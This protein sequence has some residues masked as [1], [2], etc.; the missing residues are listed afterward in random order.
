MFR[1]QV[2][3]FFQHALSAFG[4]NQFRMAAIFRAAFSSDQSHL[5]HLVDQ[6]DHAA[7]QNTE[8]LRERSLI[9][10]GRSRDQTQYSGVSRA[11]AEMLDSL[12]KTIGGMRAQLSEE[13]RRAGGP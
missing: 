4:E 9:A 6:H 12:G 8:S 7:G 11:N 3:K 5:C 2:R 1:G 10:G 13:K